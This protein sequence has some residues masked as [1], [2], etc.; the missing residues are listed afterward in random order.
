MILLLDAFFHVVIWRGEMIQAW[1]DAGY[2][3]EKRLFIEIQ[4]TYMTI[5]RCIKV[6]TFIIFIYTNITSC[7][8]YIYSYI[9]ISISRI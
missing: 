7:Y 1:Y 3:A 6:Y 4:R 2:Q 8:I 9:C 5:Y